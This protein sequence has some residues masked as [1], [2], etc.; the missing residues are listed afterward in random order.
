MDHREEDEQ[1]G[2]DEE[3]QVYAVEA[4]VGVMYKSTEPYFVGC[5]PPAQRSRSV[6][7]PPWQGTATSVR[8]ES[9]NPFP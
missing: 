6:H 4:V 8:M 2:E 1:A 5:A 7:S 9:P 3:L